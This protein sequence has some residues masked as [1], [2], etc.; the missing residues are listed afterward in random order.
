VQIDLGEAAFEGEHYSY[1]VVVVYRAVVV[2]GARTRLENLEEGQRIDFLESAVVGDRFVH[3]LGAG[4]L[5]FG[6]L[7]FGLGLAAAVVVYWETFQGIHA[8]ELETKTEGTARK[9]ACV[10]ELLRHLRTLK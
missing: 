9:W 2:V 4:V 5:E 10:S 1:Q 3:C 6:I 8:L 7:E